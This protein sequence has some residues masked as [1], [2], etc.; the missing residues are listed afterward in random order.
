MTPPPLREVLPH[1]DLIMDPTQVA[2]MAA[3]VAEH[4]FQLSSGT[5]VLVQEQGEQIGKLL[6]AVGGPGGPNTP[7]T[8]LYAYVDRRIATRPNSIVEDLAETVTQERNERN[9]RNV[10]IR[11]GLWLVFS[12]LLVGGGAALVSRGCNW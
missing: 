6:A 1:E 10:T 3:R 11:Q 7:A 4:A 8:G 9:K 12:W 5:R 2:G